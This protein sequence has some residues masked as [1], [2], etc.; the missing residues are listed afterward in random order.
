VGRGGGAIAPLAVGSLAQSGGFDV[1]F[2]A[3]GI[4]FAFAAF[5]W[6]FIPETHGRELE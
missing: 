5:M 4:A 2:G 1:A 3:S 6:F